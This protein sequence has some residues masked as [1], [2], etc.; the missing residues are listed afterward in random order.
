MTSGNKPDKSKKPKK[1]P[2]EKI[3]FD[4]RDPTKLRNP[5]DDVIVDGWRRLADGTFEKVN[6]VEDVEEV[7]ENEQILDDSREDS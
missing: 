1:Q 2:G 3:D 5:E 7:E 6:I 4:W